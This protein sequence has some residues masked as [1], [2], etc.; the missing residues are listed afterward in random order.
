MRI[1]IEQINFQKNDTINYYW[2]CLIDFE[3]WTKK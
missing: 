3:F 2:G 1:I